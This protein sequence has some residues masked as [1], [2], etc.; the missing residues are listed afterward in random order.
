M[1]RRFI[2]WALATEV[3]PNFNIFTLFVFDLELQAS[4]IHPTICLEIENSM[5]GL[6]VNV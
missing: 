4:F 2:F 6:Y 1:S 3:P 5:I